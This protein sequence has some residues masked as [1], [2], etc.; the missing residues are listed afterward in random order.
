[1]CK[2]WLSMHSRLVLMSVWRAHAHPLAQERDQPL[3]TIQ[4]GAKHI[5]SEQKRFLTATVKDVSDWCNVL[6]VGMKELIHFPSIF[7]FFVEP[8]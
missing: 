7:F 4:P 8:I 5:S 3:S 1:M 2:N 6:T